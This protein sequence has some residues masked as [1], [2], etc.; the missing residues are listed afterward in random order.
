MFLSREILKRP[1]IQAAKAALENVSEGAAIRLLAMQHAED[2]QKA[3]AKRYGL[4]RST[5]RDPCPFRI[6]RVRHPERPFC[7]SACAG[8]QADHLSMWNFAGKP[9]VVVSQ[10]YGLNVVE[11]VA[12]A[13]RHGFHVQVQAWPAWHFPHRVFHV[14][15]T[16]P[17]MRKVLDARWQ[18]RFQP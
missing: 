13:Q 1:E 18:E 12:W 10:P 7:N 5:V 15:I 9:A 2:R 3:W 14:E 6:L 11:L 17:Q 16:S 4:K 8:P